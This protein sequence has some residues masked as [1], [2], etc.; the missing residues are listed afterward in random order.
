M[1]MILKYKREK[2]KKRKKDKGEYR[3]KTN[4]R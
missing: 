2:D 4:K 3:N 1:R